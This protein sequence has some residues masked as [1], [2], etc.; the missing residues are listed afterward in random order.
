MGRVYV[1]GVGM[2][3]YVKKRAKF[4]Y[5]IVRSRQMSK[6]EKS[7][8]QQKQFRNDEVNIKS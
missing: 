4:P 6:T 8:Q 5:A 7:R 2:S 3:V 1:C